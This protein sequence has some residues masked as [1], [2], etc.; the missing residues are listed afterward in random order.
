V[1]GVSVLGRLENL[2]PSCPTCLEVRL[3]NALRAEGL[4][5]ARAPR[6]LIQCE[7]KPV[8]ETLIEDRG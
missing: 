5:K 8:S 3:E 1:D 7:G 6:T 2:Y 4:L